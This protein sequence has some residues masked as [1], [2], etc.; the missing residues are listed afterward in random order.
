MFTWTQGRREG[1][2]APPPPD[3]APD[4]F[5]VAFK[6]AQAAGWYN[7][8]TRELAPGFAISAQDIVA[9]V[10]CGDGGQAEFCVRAGAHVIMMD[11]N[12]NELEMA[13]RRT[14]NTGAGAASCLRT[15]VHTLPLADA[16]VSRVI[17][18]EVLEHVDD[19]SQVMKELV[20]IGRPGALY[21]LSVPG[22]AAE[23]LMREVAAP[24]YFEKPNHVRI[25]EPGEF[26]SLIEK[27]GLMIENQ[28]SQ[29]FYWTLYWLFFWQAGIEFGQGSH[30]LL[31]AWVKTWD[32]VLKSKQ[33]QALR[34][35]LAELAPRSIGVV[36]RKP[37]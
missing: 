3:I 8:E 1:K 28:C 16:S 5:A 33:S 19:P 2:T 24:G 21:L 7:Y 35:A 30:P 31:D 23:R 25:F 14:T 18:T 37:S 26:I 6:E 9:D 27:S 15:D 36:A 34:I 4:A 11:A 22:A 12:Q 10:G 13:A 29:G 20:R 32:E 17:C